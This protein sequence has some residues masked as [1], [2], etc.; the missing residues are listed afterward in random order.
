MLQLP[1]SD[2]QA[3]VLH[4]LRHLIARKGE[5]PFLHNPLLLPTVQHFPDPWHGDV[6][7]L[8]ALCVR[9]LGYAG[10]HGLDVGIQRF[11]G[12]ESV[13]HVSLT[14]EAQ[15]RHHGAAAWFGG[16]RD[17]VVSFG[18]AERELTHAGE[19]LVGIMAHEVAHVYR[20]AHGLEVADRELEERLTDLTTIYLGF[21]IF[22]VNNTHRYRTSTVER[23]AK[24]FG[25]TSM[26]RAGYLPAETM[27]FAFAAQVLARDLGWW[28]MRRTLRWLEPNQRG[29]AK[30][31]LRALRP[32]ERLRR[33]LLAKDPSEVDLTRQ[34]MG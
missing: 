2:V 7:S 14:G 34:A 20:C 3:W 12:Q 6:A 8:K 17:G 15:Y 30:A 10:L 25:R 9:L 13:N 26:Y 29:Y 1:P 22:T 18:C 27:S 4:E 16:I 5:R 33:R 19:Q 28:N 31:A 24:L 11:N 23:G 32:S 21:G